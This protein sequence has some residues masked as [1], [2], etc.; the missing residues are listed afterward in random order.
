M[1][2]YKKFQNDTVKDKFDSY[3]SNIKQKLLFLRQLIFK[4]ASATDNVG[5][6]E[7]TLKWGE[8]S[9]ITSE[10]KSGSTIRIDW[11]KS[12]PNQYAMYF[13]CK[14]TLVD[15]FKEIYGDI[16]QYGGNRSIIFEITDQIPVI[17]LSDC[18]SMALTYHINKKGGKNEKRKS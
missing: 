2:K 9:Y 10:T 15:T 6:I 11:K 17:E 1:A 7:E 8:P 16:F 13:N 4:V 3:P 18:I 12:T 14:T 5:P